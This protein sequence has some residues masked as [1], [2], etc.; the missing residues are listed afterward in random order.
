MIIEVAQGSVILH[1]REGS[2]DKV[3]VA[4]IKV[5]SDSREF[6]VVCK[7][8]RRGK[9]LSSQE[10]ASYKSLRAAQGARNEIVREKVK[11]GY[12]DVASLSYD[13]PVH[14]LQE[15][16]KGHLEGDIRVRD[17]HSVIVTPWEDDC[18]A[19]KLQEDIRNGNIKQKPQPEA[20]LCV[21]NLGLENHFDLDIE[22]ELVGGTPEATWLS[23]IDRFGDEVEVNA[24]RFVIPEKV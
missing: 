12:V 15:Q 19:V 1:C 18:E 23:V 11:K 2:S 17:D 16:F 3:Y 10:K 13:G 22:Y 4:N 9:N 8:G 24:D 20:V 6:V 5:D 21:D 14:A 7:W